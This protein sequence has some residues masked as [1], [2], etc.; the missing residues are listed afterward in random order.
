MTTRICPDC[1]GAIEVP[2]DEEIPA[3]SIVRHPEGQ[4]PGTERDQLYRYVGTYTV[5]RLR[6]RSDR[7][8]VSI[9]DDADDVDEDGPMLASVSSWMEARTFKEIGAELATQV[10]TKIQ[11]MLDHATVIDLPEESDAHLDD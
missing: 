2:D 11:I 8:S 5:H 10:G 7:A 9:D 4:C 3:G 6:V 1:G